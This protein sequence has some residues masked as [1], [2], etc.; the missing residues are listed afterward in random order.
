MSQGCRAQRL[1]APRIAPPCARARAQVDYLVCMAEVFL[2]IVFH[3]EDRMCMAR[4]NGLLWSR[5]AA[6]D[7]PEVGGWRCAEASAP[8]MVRC[9]QRERGCATETATA[10]AAGHAQ[11]CELRGRSAIL[12]DS[13]AVCT[14]LSLTPAPLEAQGGPVGLQAWPTSDVCMDLLN[15]AQNDGLSISYDELADM[16]LDFDITSEELTEPS[17]D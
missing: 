7:A 11:L 10:E 9:L 5:V 17:T 4:L 13:R 15:A 16:G 1:R 8:V 14:V 3:P 6:P 2:A 12:P